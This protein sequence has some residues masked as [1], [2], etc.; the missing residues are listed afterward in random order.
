[1]LAPELSR[2]VARFVEMQGEQAT[3]HELSPT[4]TLQCTYFENSVV[5]ATIRFNAIPLATCRT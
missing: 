2:A 1:M 3:E 5:R 4:V